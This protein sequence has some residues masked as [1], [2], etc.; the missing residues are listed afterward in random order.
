MTRMTVADRLILLLLLIFCIGF[1]W[2]LW[3]ALT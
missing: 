2:A 3:E 1:W